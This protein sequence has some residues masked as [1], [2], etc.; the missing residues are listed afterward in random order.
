MKLDF[1]C[2]SVQVIE[3]GIGHDVGEA[4]IYSYVAVD[5]GV[6]EALVDMANTTLETM[7]NLTD[8]PE[9]YQPSEKH[10][11]VEYLYLPLDDDLAVMMRELHESNNLPMDATA[12][13]NAGDIFCYFARFID[14]QGRR[15]TAIRRASQFKGVL[16]KRLIQFRTDSLKIVEDKVFKLDGDFDLLVDALNVHILRPSGFE[17]IGQLQKAVL[18][19]VTTNV[20][21]LRSD[22]AFV[23]LDI[24]ESYASKHPRA[25]R[26]LAS[27]RSKGEA[28][29]IDR[30]RLLQLCGHTGVET[31]ETEQG[32]VAV[33]DKHVM[34]FLE[35]LDRRRYEIELVVNSPEKYRAASRSKIGSAK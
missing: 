16:K 26:Y 12:L 30:S 15:L 1:N 4:R 24:V 7:H 14:G 19:A 23:D 13:D 28:Q 21:A 34:G 25:A 32:Q 11:G 9:R 10:S 6:Q 27:I 35:V 31:S 8:G 3:F 5:G 17:F 18:G 22:L 29:N 33:T 20:V 2:D